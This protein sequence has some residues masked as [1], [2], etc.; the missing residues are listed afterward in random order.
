[1]D[2]APAHQ[3]HALPFGNFLHIFFQYVQYHKAIIK[4]LFVSPRPDRVRKTP[5]GRKSFLVKKVRYFF[6][7]IKSWSCLFSMSTLHSRIRLIETLWHDE[8]GENIT[9][10]ST[11]RLKYC[12]PP[13]KHPYPSKRLL[14]PFSI[15][16]FGI[17]VA[18]LAAYHFRVTGQLV[19]TQYMQ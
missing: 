18:Q 8:D 2:P 3:E 13:I 1:V 5:P 11:V 14:R 9:L 6:K 12:I 7:K 10:S 19:L 17:P 4:K 16:L 15:S